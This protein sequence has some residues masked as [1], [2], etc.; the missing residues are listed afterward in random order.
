MHIAQCAIFIKWELK[1]LK[2]Y[3]TIFGAQKLQIHLNYYHL[4][5][6]SWFLLVWINY[7]ILTLK[8][9]PVS[10]LCRYIGLGFF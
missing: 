5:L 3:L 7:D 10:Q 4:F 2:N 9:E 8:S 1:V 6:N